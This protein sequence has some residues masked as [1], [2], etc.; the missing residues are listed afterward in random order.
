M[1]VHKL[2]SALPVHALYMFHNVYAL[3]IHSESVNLEW[4]IRKTANE[5]CAQPPR[6]QL[7]SQPKHIMEHTCCYDMPNRVFQYVEATVWCDVSMLEWSRYPSVHVDTWPVC[8]CSASM[9][10][11]SWLISFWVPAAQELRKRSSWL[12]TSHTSTPIR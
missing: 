12:W 9:D 11:G 4:N 8:L 6:N 3:H 5:L 1:S 10:R 7:A 2:R